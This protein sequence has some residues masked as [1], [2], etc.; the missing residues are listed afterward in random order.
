MDMVM[1]VPEVVDTGFAKV[2]GISS[3]ALRVAS[4]ESL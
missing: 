4:Y 3:V 1:G 2:I